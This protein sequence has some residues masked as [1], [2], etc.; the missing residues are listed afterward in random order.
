MKYHF[1]D[2]LILNSNMNSFDM[3]LIY[4]IQVFM[5]TKNYLQNN[6]A[7]IILLRTHKNNKIWSISIPKYI[8]DFFYQ[9]SYFYYSRQKF[10]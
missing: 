2:N 7:S 9:F 8:K 1:E 10:I 3:I 5:E 6:M 4:S